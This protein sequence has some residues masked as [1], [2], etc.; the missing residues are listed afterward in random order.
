MFNQPS[1]IQPEHAS[2][3]TISHVPRE[4][5]MFSLGEHELDMLGGA[6]SSLWQTFC[7]ITAGTAVTTLVTFLTVSLSDRAFGAFVAV[8]VATAVLAIAFLI[9]TIIER[10][11]ISATIQR[12]KRR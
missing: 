8:F 3:V 10:R 12:L 4:L 7:G 2:P 6:Y 5:Q 1:T 11:R 9:A